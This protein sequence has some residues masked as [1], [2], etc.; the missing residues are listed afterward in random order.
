MSICPL[1]PSLHQCKPN[2]VYSQVQAATG[3]FCSWNCRISESHPCR[4]NLPRVLGWSTCQLVLFQCQSFADKGHSVRIL[5]QFPRYWFPLSFTSPVSMPCFKKSPLSIPG[6]QHIASDKLSSM[7]NGPAHL[8]RLKL[9]TV[10]SNSSNVKK[11]PIFSAVKSFSA[12]LQNGTDGGCW[13]PASPISTTPERAP[14]NCSLWF[15]FT[16]EVWWWLTHHKC[17]YG[18]LNRTA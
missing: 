1:N 3:T 17:P 5:Q 8:V 10:R 4:P 18:K 6:A 15:S 9:M 11:G 14:H 7:W 2:G 13:S 12:L 16:W